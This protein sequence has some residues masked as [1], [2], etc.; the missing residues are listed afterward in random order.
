MRLSRVMYEETDLLDGIG[1]VR[2]SQG[3]ILESTGET[4]ILCWIHNR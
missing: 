1:N 2:A 4:A 3:E